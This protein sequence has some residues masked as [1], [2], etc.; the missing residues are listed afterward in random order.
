MAE[1]KHKHTH[2]QVSFF[3]TTLLIFIDDVNDSEK[4]R[5]WYSTSEI[6]TFKK[7]AA[8]TIRELQSTA[9]SKTTSDHTDASDYMGLEP[10]LSKEIEHEYKRHRIQHSHAVLFC[11]KQTGDDAPSPELL[12]LVSQR[13]A[14]FAVDHAHAAAVFYA[15]RKFHEPDSLKRNSVAGRCA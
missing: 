1:T 4:N 12:A 14:K 11:S 9:T 2:K 3:G 6:A 8:V 15:S 5:F 10:F 13:K 7:E